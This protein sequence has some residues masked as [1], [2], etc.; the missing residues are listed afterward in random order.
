MDAGG[1]ISGS[2]SDTWATDSLIANNISWAVTIPAKLAA[3][4]R[5]PPRDHCPARGELDR[6]AGISAVC[7]FFR[8]TGGSK[9]ITGDVSAETFLYAAGSGNL[10]Q[11][12]Y[13]FYQLYNS[14]AGGDGI[15]E[16][17]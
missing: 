14:R 12:V 6:R 3:E 15:E 7:G 10:V 17:R 8:I 9:T 13:H 5:Y 16:E 4:L 1:W 2:N 11:S